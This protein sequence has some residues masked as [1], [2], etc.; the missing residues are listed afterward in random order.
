MKK[1]AYFKIGARDIPKNYFAKY[2][3]IK[4]IFAAKYYIKHGENMVL[5]EL[6]MFPTDKGESVSRWVSQV[7]DHIDKSGITYKLTPMGTVLEGEWDEVMSVISACFHIL[8]PQC[9]RIY[10]TLKVDYRKGSESRMSSKI[11]KIESLLSRDV[12]HS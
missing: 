10:S 4:H 12:K 8:E 6:T 11:D 5:A 3:Q 9:G 7:I 2:L 1:I